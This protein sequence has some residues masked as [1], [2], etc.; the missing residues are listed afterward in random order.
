MLAQI[1]L[2]YYTLISGQAITKKK[3]PYFEGESGYF[4]AL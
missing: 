1:S 2:T 4:R 3:K